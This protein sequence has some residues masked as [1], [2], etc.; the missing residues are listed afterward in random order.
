M[1]RPFAAVDRYKLGYVFLVRDAGFNL[2]NFR[3]GQAS[4]LWMLSVWKRQSDLKRNK[5]QK[6]KVDLLDTFIFK[7]KK[8]LRQS[9]ASV[10]TEHH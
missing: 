10:T 4:D 3:M 5:R 6:D 8:K 2:N 9:K 1:A 7:I